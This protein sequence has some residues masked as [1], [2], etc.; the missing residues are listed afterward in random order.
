MS[1]FHQL[2]E[3][4]W[5]GAPGKAGELR[6]DRAFELP[7]ATLA[8][9]VLLT[10][11]GVLFSL[12]I[13][14][15]SDRMGVPD[16]RPLPD[17]WILWLNSALLVVSSVG[18]QQALTNAR[19]GEIEGVKSGLLIGGVFAL[20]FLLGQLWAWKELAD[21]GYFAATNPA[22][23][24]FYLITGLHGLHLLGGL[25]AWGRTADKVWRGVEAA[26]VRA[27]VE[28]CTAYWHFLLVLWV[29]LFGLM[30]FT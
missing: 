26:R 5:E 19:R 2:M 22:Y 13:V 20:A 24:F 8:L 3:K 1:L 30:L 11:I 27:S 7:S 14:A 15:Y 12:L 25:V 9:R 16:W 17:P 29:I 6:H 28:L 10:V 4:P 21:L 18:L 23:A